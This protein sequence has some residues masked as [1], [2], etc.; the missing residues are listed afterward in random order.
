VNNWN[1]RE[2]LHYLDDYFTLGPP[3][4]DICAKRLTRPRPK[5]AYPYLLT[6]AW[7]PQH[8]WFSLAFG[9][10]LSAHDCSTTRWQTRRAHSIVGGVGHQALLQTKGS[11]VTSGK[12]KPRMCSRPPGT[13]IFASFARLV[14]G[15]FYSKQS[16]FIRLN[17]ECKLDIDWWRTF[18]YMG[19]WVL[20]WSTGVDPSPRPFHLYRRLRK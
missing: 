17:K 14:K 13:H 9:V 11:L 5:L 12:I 16:R 19:R 20:L 15:P 10:R 7:A 18:A 6:N 8:V 1:V 3:N 2:L 4:S